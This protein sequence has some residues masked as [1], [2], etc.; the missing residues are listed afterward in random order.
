MPDD[1]PLP[2]DADA[3]WAEAQALLSG[4]PDAAAE[5]RLRRTLRRRVLAVL[6][7]TLGAGVLVWL[8]VLLAADGGESS[9]PGVPL[10]QVVTGFALATVGLV[11]AG[12]AVVRQ[13]RAV[14]RRRVR[15]GP[16]FVLAVSQRRELLAQV[17]GRVPVDPARVGLARRTAEDLQHQRHTVWTNVGPSVL[18]TGLAVALPSWWRVTAAAAYLLLTVVAGGLAQRGA[19]SAQTFLVAHR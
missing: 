13:V 16:L 11:V 12:V 5:Q 15:N 19:R 1:Q 4:G 10:R 17:R 14:R 7:A 3:R 9:S 6:G 8:V 2:R 18:W